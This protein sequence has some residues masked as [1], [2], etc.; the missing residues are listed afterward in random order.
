MKHAGWIDRARRGQLCV[1]HTRHVDSYQR[2]PN[3]V[4]EEFTAGTVEGVDADGVITRY[5][6]IDGHVK[7]LKNVP[8][9]VMKFTLTAVEP[10]RKA[11]LAALKSRGSCTFFTIEEAQNFFKPFK[12][13]AA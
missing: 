11:A 6:T 5:R 1:I 8:G 2:G 7:I 4:R 9:V 10:N 13:A 3:Q 12:A